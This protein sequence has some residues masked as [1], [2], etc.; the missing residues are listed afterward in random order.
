[1]DNQLD[2]GDPWLEGLRYLDRLVGQKNISFPNPEAKSPICIQLMRY[3]SHSEDQFW[4]TLRHCDGS[5]NDPVAVACPKT[6]TSDGIAVDVDKLL[7]KLQHIAQTAAA[8]G[9]VFIHA[10]HDMEYTFVFG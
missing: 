1:M 7:S 5:P 8:Q 3:D 9:M 6:H 10:N 2:D 4:I